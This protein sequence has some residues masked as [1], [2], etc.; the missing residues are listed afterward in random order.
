MN[1]DKLNEYINKRKDE[2]YAGIKAT[3][4]SRYYIERSLME[5]R[6]DELIELEKFIQSEPEE[7]CTYG[8]KIRES[9]ENLS[10][11]IRGQFGDD[12]VYHNGKVID[13]DE[14]LNKKAGE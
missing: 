12:R 8:Y 7:T 2:I 13:L 5:N 6:L 1:K 9:N 11:F 3:V 10:G 4:N 14:F